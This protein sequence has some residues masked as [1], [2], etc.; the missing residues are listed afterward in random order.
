MAAAERVRVLIIKAFTE[1]YEK[2]WPMSDRSVDD[3]TPQA[4][5]VAI[6]NNWIVNN[7]HKTR[8]TG[9]LDWPY[10]E[11][12]NM[13]PATVRLAESVINPTTYRGFTNEWKFPMAKALNEQWGTEPLLG[14]VLQTLGYWTDNCPTLLLE[15]QSKRNVN[16]KMELGKIRVDFGDIK[17]NYPSYYPPVLLTTRNGTPPPKM[18]PHT[19][20]MHDEY[21]VG[22][23]DHTEMI[24]FLLPEFFEYQDSDTFRNAEYLYLTYYQVYFDQKTKGINPPYN[25]PKKIQK[26]HSEAISVIDSVLAPFRGYM[27]EDLTYEPPGGTGALRVVATADYRTIV[28][29]NIA[30]VYYI[31]RLNCSSWIKKWFNDPSSYLP[32]RGHLQDELIQPPKKYVGTPDQ[33]FQQ[34]FKEI[35]HFLKDKPMPDLDMYIKYHKKFTVDDVEGFLKPEPSVYK[36]TRANILMT[37]FDWTNGMFYR[38]RSDGMS[39]TFSFVDKYKEKNVGMPSFRLSEAHFFPGHI[40][41]DVGD[42]ILQTLLW[43]TYLFCKVFHKRI[44]EKIKDEDLPEDIIEPNPDPIDD[45]IPRPEIP[46][47]QY[48]GAIAE[49]SLNGMMNQWIETGQWSFMGWNANQVSMPKEELLLA[50][51]DYD[52]GLTYDKLKFMESFPIEPVKRRKAWEGTPEYASEYAIVLRLQWEAYLTWVEFNVLAKRNAKASKFYVLPGKPMVDLSGNPI[53]G[54]D[55]KPLLNTPIN[56]GVFLE[57]DD[58]PPWWAYLGIGWFFNVIGDL[59]GSSY[60]KAING[61]VS[62]VFK[63]VLDTLFGIAE[64]IWKNLPDG[65]TFLWLLLIPVAIIL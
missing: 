36:C 16:T 41:V 57:E 10:Y 35:E 48:W 50:V 30:F 7:V 13:P 4:E 15:T 6:Y 22:L 20:G 11:N 21:V 59:W 9:I 5:R 56:Y 33:I 43:H 58:A 62:K 8:M 19:Q 46:K 34:G 44:L 26:D 29:L 55:G 2:F 18:V 39:T 45:T 40:D 31:S 63:G 14:V 27:W 52:K 38:S 12:N 47:R 25:L 60:W 28:L 54:P 23:P 64:Y 37:S 32:G 49:S 61:T 3:N 17:R 1:F 51:K 65:S 42:T 24:R 53:T